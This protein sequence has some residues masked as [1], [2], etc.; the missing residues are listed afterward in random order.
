MV[1]SIAVITPCDVFSGANGGEGVFRGIIGA[2][3][4]GD[5]SCIS[6]KENVHMISTKFIIKN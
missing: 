1:N 6:S 5:D 4:T 2:C 3:T